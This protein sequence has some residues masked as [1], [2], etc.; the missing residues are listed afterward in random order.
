MRVEAVS[1]RRV[2]ERTRPPSFTTGPGRDGMSGCLTGAGAAGWRQPPD[3][4]H[5]DGAPGGGRTGTRR[6]AR[7]DE[8]DVVDSAAARLLTRLT[9]QTASRRHYA[10][11]LSQSAAARV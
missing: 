7:A 2:E 1:R 9:E 8:P 4:R 10:A 11:L 6:M 3:V 5:A